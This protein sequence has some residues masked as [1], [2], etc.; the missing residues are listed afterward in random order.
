MFVINIKQQF[1]NEQGEFNG[2]IE[3]VSVLHEMLQTSYDYIIK[4][5]DPKSFN[6]QSKNWKIPLQV[7]A[8]SKI[9]ID[10]CATYFLKTLGAL[11]L[12]EK[13]VASYTSLNKDVFP[14]SAYYCGKQNVFYLRKYQSYRAILSIAHNQIIYLRNYMVQPAFDKDDISIDY[15]KG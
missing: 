8:I 15:K 5:G 13:E 3:M 11:S 4:G 7:S 2:V 10:F 6:K 14:I 12:S 1:L 9:N